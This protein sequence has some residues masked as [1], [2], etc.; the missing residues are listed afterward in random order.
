MKTVPETA[1]ISSAFE[2]R[3]RPDVLKW[4]VIDVKNV[5]S[6]RVIF[7]SASFEGRH[8]VWLMTEG[9]LHV[10]GARAA[11]FDLWQDTA[12][13]CVEIGIESKRGK[14]HV[15]NIWDR[16]AGRRS[17]AWTSGMLVEELPNGRRYKCNDIGFSEAFDSVV[18]RLELAV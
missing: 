6:I 16:G 1:Q 15:Y 9:T 5:A 10:N 17:Q 2:E 3:G 13:P 14:L 12:P 8:G 18:F 4:D 11:S 7:E